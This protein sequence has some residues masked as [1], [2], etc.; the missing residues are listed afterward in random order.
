M[1]KIW[2]FSTKNHVGPVKS[3]QDLAALIDSLPQGQDIDADAQLEIFTRSFDDKHP[4]NAIVVDSKLRVAEKVEEEGRSLPTLPTF[5]KSVE[6]LAL[7]RRLVLERAPPKPKKPKK[8]NSPPPET[9]NSAQTGGRGSGR[10]GGKGTGD[11]GGS[12]TGKGGKGEP[13]RAVNCYYC[14]SPL[15]RTPSAGECGG[16]S[17]CKWRHHFE[18]LQALLLDTNG[19]LPP[20][21]GDMLKGKNI[22]TAYHSARKEVSRNHRPPS[23]SDRS[24]S[25]ETDD[26]FEDD[27]RSTVSRRSKQSERSS[28][29]KSS[30]KSK[31]G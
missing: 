20:G 10:K 26:G 31:R 23:D 29:R 5:A 22:Q 7:T 18:S 15:A 19:Q 24:S 3:A 17:T 13:R 27:A 6:S 9:A 21:L 11:G 25:S 8:S 16:P 14:K 4:F 28:N 1:T 12:G 30:R 2:T